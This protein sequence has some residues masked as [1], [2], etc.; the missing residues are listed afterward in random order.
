[1][2]VRCVRNHQQITALAVV[3]WLSL[4]SQ[5]GYSEGGKQWSD[6]ATLVPLAD[7]GRELPEVARQ[8]VATT[9]NF[10]K[11]FALLFVVSTVVTLLFLWI[12]KKNRG[13][14]GRAPPSD[15]GQTR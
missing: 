14:V 5:T 15:G 4:I 7:L 10:F 13:A 9:S 3:L 6:P 12:Q 2:I 11:L 1:M 8:P